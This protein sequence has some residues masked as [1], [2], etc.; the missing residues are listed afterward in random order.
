M[1]KGCTACKIQCSSQVGL[2]A[3][4]YYFPTKDVHE[5]TSYTWYNRIVMGEQ[6][7]MPKQVSDSNSQVAEGATHRKGKSI[8]SARLDS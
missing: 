5:Y 6:V 8:T 4:S 2:I 1:D 7:L 3:V